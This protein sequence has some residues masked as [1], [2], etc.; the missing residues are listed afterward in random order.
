[1]ADEAPGIVEP[2]VNTVIFDGKLLGGIGDMEA[3]L[4]GTQLFSVS[5]SEDKLVVF[6][7][8]TRD[9]QRR[10]LLF[11]IITFR[12]DSV[13][14]DYSV[15]KD[16][17]E[18]LRKLS[19]LRNL[20]GVLSVVSKVYSV[21]Q[22]S[23]YEYVD[24]AIDDVI[25]SMSQGY[26]TLFN[27]YDSLLA[28]HRE[29]RRLNLELASSNKSLTA[30][31]TRISRENEELK[32]KLKAL[33][34]YSDES[35]MVMVQE[36]IESHNSTIDMAEFAKTYKVTQPRIEQILNRMVAAGYIELRG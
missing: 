12:K 23:L 8:E 19:V 29:L 10:P 17:S 21:D 32:D 3:S 11:F 27:S 26:S 14:L 1:M 30:D 15:P 16:T 31:A 36:W 28:E 20:M 33:E 35:L 4:S 25:A 18:K 24:A 7:V 34:N 9:M 5:K 22:K 6:N 2:S 13:E